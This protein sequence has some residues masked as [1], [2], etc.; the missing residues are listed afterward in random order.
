MRGG[1]G[2]RITS[3][4]SLDTLLTKDRGF[5]SRKVRK[6]LAGCKN[7]EDVGTGKG[8]ARGENFAPMVARIKRLIVK[9]T[10]ASAVRETKDE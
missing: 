4:G 10:R 6:G 1:G 7:G 3:R 9:A 2:G 8:V 5:P